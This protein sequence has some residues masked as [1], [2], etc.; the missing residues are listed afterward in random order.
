MRRPDFHPDIRWPAAIMA[1]SAFALAGCSF[2]RTTTV[3]VTAPN[4]PTHPA[5]PTPK[6]KKPSKG[7]VLTKS[8]MELPL[9][10][11][12]GEYEQ[13]FQVEGVASTE[14]DYKGAIDQAAKIKDPLIQVE[15]Q[16]AIDIDIA[17]DAAITAGFGDSPEDAVKE[18]KL[19]EDPGLRA[20][21]ALAIELK[22]A[23]N[24]IF[25]LVDGD[26]A[27]AKIESKKIK[28]P[29]IQRLV[30]RAAAQAKKN[31][32]LEAY[33]TQDAIENRILN[34]VNGLEDQQTYASQQIF[35]HT[36]YYH[37]LYKKAPEK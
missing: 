9:F 18:L 8:E 12:G 36:N 27:N 17:H 28:T 34:L 22:R 37:N 14:Y 35:R 30:G 2:D 15:T 21:V 19:V 11:K 26:A 10:P 23:D 16:V 33:A 3:T 31:H 25:D 5:K 13:A 7:H 20:K 1:A 6:P 29:W 24:L 32:D 4:A